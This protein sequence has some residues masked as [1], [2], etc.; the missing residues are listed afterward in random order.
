[1]TTFALMVLAWLAFTFVL[2]APHGRMLRAVWREP[3]LA[4]PVV[5]VESD[6][7]GP[8]PVSDALMLRRIAQ[9][10]ADIRDREGR[11]ALM[12][13]GVVLGK[14]DGAAILAAD[15]QRYHRRVLDEEAYAPIVEAM[16]EGCATGV[17]ALQRHGLEHCWPASLLERARDD[18]E[19][20]HWLANPD[21]RSESL[22]SALQSRWVDAAILPSGALPDTEIEAAV[23][24]EGDVF[25]RLF[26]A[27]PTVAVPNT[28]VW[29]AAVERAWAADG[30]Q[31]IVTCG[32]Q[33]E[34]RDAEGG[35]MP[36]TRQVFNGE[37]GIGGIHYVVRDVYFEPIRGHRAERV[38]QGV[39]ERTALG[40]PA[41]IETHRESFIGPPEA[42]GQALAELVRALRGVV[43]HYPDVCFLTTAA[44]V[45]VFAA[46][47]SSPLIV[48]GL[49]FRAAVFLR[50][51]LAVPA[52]SRT[53]KLSGLSFMLPALIGVLARVAPAPCDGQAAC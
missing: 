35:L 32:R 13:L 9:Q 17:F 51:L 50:R 38:W 1:M 44:V 20:R 23:R 11:P 15:C 21:A 45:D 52:L 47:R 6:D 7:W 46:S 36:P 18:V 37:Q 48:R 41:L 8:G 4:R 39:A 19:L 34:G 29:R 12:T 30:V 14:P 27:R 24:E 33:Y 43:A 40:R 49:V 26:G 31:C 10:L 22:P 3:V 53:L 2:F 42:A 16:R 25:Q 28:F 5:I